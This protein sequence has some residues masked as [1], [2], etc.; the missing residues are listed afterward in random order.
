M[1]FEEGHNFSFSNCDDF[2]ARW[3]FLRE[4]ILYTAS[5]SKSRSFRFILNDFNITNNFFVG[6]N[7]FLGTSGQNNTILFLSNFIYV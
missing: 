7:F 3:W 6:Q 1:D 4:C 5:Y 2:H